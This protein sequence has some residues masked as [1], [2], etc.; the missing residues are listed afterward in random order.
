MNG[1]GFWRGFCPLLATLSIAP[2]SFQI[3]L[4]MIA[5]LGAGAPAAYALLAR[6]ALLD[7]VLVAAVGGVASVIV[8]KEHDTC[9]RSRIVAQLWVVALVVGGGAGAIGCLTYPSGLT[10][11][12]GTT[13]AVRLARSALG[14][15]LAAIPFRVLSGV[16]L[17]IL[18]A[19]ERGRVALCW[20]SFEIVL[21]AVAAYTLVYPLGFGFKGCFIAGLVAATAGATVTFAAAR[22]DHDAAPRLPSWA[23]ARSFL[24]QSLCEAARVLS[25]QLLVLTS[26]ALFA[27]PWIGRFEPARAD[28]YAA[29]QILVLLLFTPFTALT[30]FLAL[31]LSDWPRPEIASQIV[32]LWRQ[33][34]PVAIAAGTILLLS[35]GWIGQAIYQQEGRWWSTFVAAL[36]LSLPIRFATNVMRGALQA[37][38]RFAD[39][40]AVDGLVACFVALP[41]TALGLHLDEPAVAYLALIAPEAIC[42]AVL[43]RRLS[44]PREPTPQPALQC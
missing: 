21:K 25:P 20:K 15:Y 42:A 33:G 40:A 31:R 9:G 28:A 12:G 43:W 27:A 17:F 8:A 41:L 23:F 36:A 10:L 38:G 19:T 11:I 2:V 30:R 37:D 24:A 34:I 39:A 35:S 7:A 14:W 29:G 44:D 5:R 32:H 18:F 13:D 26:L 16:G 4:A 22:R 3:D 6:V 1:R